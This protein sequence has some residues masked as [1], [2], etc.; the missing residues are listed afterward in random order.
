MCCLPYLG[1][2]KRTRV[3][4]SNTDE[5]SPAAVAPNRKRERVD[6]TRGYGIKVEADDHIFYHRISALT[7]A[8]GRV[9]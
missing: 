8:C 5:P 1:R 7:S 9:G 3:G 2:Y 6:P 4:E